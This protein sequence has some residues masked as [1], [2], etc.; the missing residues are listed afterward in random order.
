MRGQ[1]E[2]YFLGAGHLDL[3]KVSV[4]KQAGGRNLKGA[5]RCIGRQEQQEFGFTLCALLQALR[6]T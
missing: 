3:V 4:L 5:E 6:G 1:Y 2:Q